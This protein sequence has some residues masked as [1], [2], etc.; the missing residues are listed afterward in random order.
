MRKLLRMGRARVTIT[1][2]LG[3]RLQGSISR[4][5]PAWRIMD[6]LYARILLLDDGENRL[7]LVA[8]DLIEFSREFAAGLKKKMQNLYGIPEQWVLLCPSHTHT[9]PPTILLGSLLPDPDYLSQLE[10]HILGAVLSASR[11]MRE[12]RVSVGRGEAR[13]VGINRRL[14]TPRG[15][16]QLPNPQGPVDPEL[17]VVRFDDPEEGQP[18]AAVVNF[19][20]HPTTLGIQIYQ[21]SADYPGRMIRTV[22]E[23][24]GACLEVLFTQGACGDV[25][26][27]ALEANGNFK[28]G[29]EEDIDRLGR[30]LGAAVIDTLE[31]CR[32]IEDVRLAAALKT[33]AFPY[34][35]LPV[36]HELESLIAR[37]REEAARWQTPDRDLQRTV[38]W[39]DKHIN[40]VLMHQDMAQWAERMLELNRT[41]A[42]AD[43]ASGDLQ[44]CAIGNTLA[45]VG[46]PGELFSEIGKTLKR[47]SPFEHTA[48]CAYSNG[49]LGYI[50]S[51]QAIHDGGY[52]VEDAYKLYGFPACFQ[53]DT[54][55]MLCREVGNLLRQLATK[56]DKI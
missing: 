22:Q 7:L 50:P 38:D 19:A 45:L 10:K 20:T 52:E 5:Q 6:D 14:P 1:P 33:V 32:E 35:S 25:K 37:H 17:Q 43:S 42:T 30:L 41:G 31:R 11:Q 40:R 18:L 8:C 29:G 9:G 53:E 3:I 12:V 34:R 49:T 56:P 2:P 15:I 23:I 44:V 27:A 24:Y 16:R 26:A 46:V 36:A 54:E 21:I 13:D 48:I 4:D 55:D 51:R 47:H 28:E 39:E